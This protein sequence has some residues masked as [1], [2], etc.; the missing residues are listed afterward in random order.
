MANRLSQIATRTGGHQSGHHGGKRR[1]DKRVRL[2]QSGGE[3][4]RALECDEDEARWDE[5]LKK[6]V[7][8]KPV[9]KPE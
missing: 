5:R 1:E 9:E 8:H 4:A 2:R 6:V 7:R 3:A